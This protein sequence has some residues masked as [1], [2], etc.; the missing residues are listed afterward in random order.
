MDDLMM[1]K[2]ITVIKHSRKEGLDDDCYNILS[3]SKKNSNKLE[4]IFHSLNNFIKFAIHAKHNTQEMLFNITNKNL[5]FDGIPINTIAKLL[6]PCKYLS[7]VI[8]S[9]EFL[10]VINKMY[11]R[12]KQENVIDK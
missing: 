2:H 5:S 6:F 4:Q 7:N 9:E 11:A 3:P 1:Y 8:L 10:E 12:P